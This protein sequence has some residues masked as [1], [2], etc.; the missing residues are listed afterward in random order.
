[1]MGLHISFSSIL[2]YLLF[3]LETVLSTNLEFVIGTRSLQCTEIEG[4]INYELLS[5][6][7]NT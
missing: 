4:C 5:A 6:V 3:V 2:Y 7:Y 1:M